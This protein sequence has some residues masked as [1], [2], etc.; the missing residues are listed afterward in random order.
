MLKT[1]SITNLNVEFEYLTVD[2]E[3]NLTRPRLGLDLGYWPTQVPA[4]DFLG[5]H[6]FERLKFQQFPFQRKHKMTRIF[7]CVIKNKYWLLFNREIVQNNSPR[8][9]ETVGLYFPR[10]HLGKYSNPRS[11]VT[12]KIS[13]MSSQYLY[14][15]YWQ[16]VHLTSHKPFQVKRN[17]WLWRFHERVIILAAAL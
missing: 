14:T 13:L 2:F 15:K 10:L 12:S 11:P 4:F 17:K 7:L 8:W 16:G 5:W 1:S 6:Y 9:L 3:L